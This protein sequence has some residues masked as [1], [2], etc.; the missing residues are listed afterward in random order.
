MSYHSWIYFTKILQRSE[1]L[2][3]IPHSILSVEGM[4]SG[5]PNNVCVK[6]LN[7]AWNWQDACQ[8]EAPQSHQLSLQTGTAAHLQTARLNFGPI[9]VADALSRLLMQK[10]TSFIFH[11]KNQVANTNHWLLFCFSTAEFAYI[12]P[13]KMK[14]FPTFYDICHGTAQ[15]RDEKGV[16]NLFHDTSAFK[17][18]LR[19]PDT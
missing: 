18:Y 19:N 4:M 17:V 9:K 2:S 15:V 16:S 3:D 12:G 5:T 1:L 13:W 10:M 11:Y 6:S 8:S 7:K 14:K